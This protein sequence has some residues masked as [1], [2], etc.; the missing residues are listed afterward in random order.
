[1]HCSHSGNP[2]V[3]LRRVLE[4]YLSYIKLYSWGRETGSNCTEEKR[5]IEQW[6]KIG[7]SGS[8]DGGTDGT[9][10]RV[11]QIHYQVYNFEVKAKMPCFQFN[12]HTAA[13]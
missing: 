2:P 13:L 5:G 4:L 8:I 1:M 7:G 3:R 10:C 11:W 12:G 6:R 9:N